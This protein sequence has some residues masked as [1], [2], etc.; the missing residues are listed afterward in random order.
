MR[1]FV[2]KSAKVVAVTVTGVVAAV[3]DCVVVVV[4]MPEVG[5]APG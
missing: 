5:T 3:V 1:S 4:S 2:E